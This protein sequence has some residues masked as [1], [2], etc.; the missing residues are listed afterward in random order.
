M[1]LEPFNRIMNT[2]NPLNAEILQYPTPADAAHA[3][4]SLLVEF[5]LRSHT[6][7]GE[8]RVALAGGNTP[9]AMYEILAT[10]MRTAIDWK[11]VHIYFG[12]ERHVPWTD[13]RSN[14][15]MAHRTLLGRVPIPRQQ[16]H[17]IQPRESAAAAAEEYHQTLIRSVKGCTASRAPQL[18]L[19]LLGLGSD[20]HVA[21]LFPGLPA[22]QVADRWAT[23]SPPGILPPDVERITLTFP[24]LNAARSVVFLACGTGKAEAVRRALQSNESRESCPARGVRTSD[25][26]T[27]W[28]LDQSAASE[29]QTKTP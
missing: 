16:I 4:A 8:F 17:G 12:D 18:D 9:A 10:S 15:F 2:P 24:V 27:V 3:A 29:I 14:Y 6:E 26:G 20:G 1:R 28:I 23:S 11:R 19:I 25:A 5:A 22:L 21:S 7:R 13:E